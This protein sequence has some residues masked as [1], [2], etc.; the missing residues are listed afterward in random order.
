MEGYS[1]S[2]LRESQMPEDV[3]HAINKFIHKLFAEK[4]NLPRGWKEKYTV[5]HHTLIR[6]LH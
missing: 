3:G 5:G 1:S 2:I 6:M 4:H